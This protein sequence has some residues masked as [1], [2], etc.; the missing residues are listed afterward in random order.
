VL[1]K[2]AYW[3]L[4]VFKTAE[5]S[6]IQKECNQVFNFTEYKSPII[7]IEYPRQLAQYKQMLKNWLLKEIEKRKRQFNIQEDTLLQSFKFIVD[8]ANKL[9]ESAEQ[10]YLTKNTPEYISYPEHIFAS[11]RAYKL[12]DWFTKHLHNG[13][14]FT[15]LYRYMRVEEKGFK[16]KVDPAPFEEWFNVQYSNKGRFKVNGTLDKV[17]RPERV[18]TYKLVKEMI[19][20]LYPS[21]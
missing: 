12:F 9:M 10:D 16:I 15:F 21:D 19:L 14:Q 6:Q 4:L 5:R 17:S 3:E 1:D 8:F 11:F 13:Q 7:F 20:E 2:W 18:N